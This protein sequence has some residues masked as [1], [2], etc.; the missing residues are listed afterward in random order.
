MPNKSK[1]LQLLMLKIGE[2]GGKKKE[3]SRYFLT[4]R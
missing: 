1:F 2:F 3:S 4:Q